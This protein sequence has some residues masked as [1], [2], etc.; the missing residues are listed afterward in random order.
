MGLVLGLLGALGGAVAGVVV[1]TGLNYGYGWLSYWL[2]RKGVPQWPWHANPIELNWWWTHDVPAG[3]SFGALSALIAMAWKRGKHQEAIRMSQ[4]GGILGIILSGLN[5][6]VYY[7]SS[8]V[9][10]NIQMVYNNNA[11]AGVRLALKVFWSVFGLD[12]TLHWSLLLL[13]TSVVLK[14]SESRIQKARSIFGLL[15]SSF[16]LLHSYFLFL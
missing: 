8:N 9:V 10:S 5:M 2:W 14:K 12:V 6:F 15:A 4:W 1:V 7:Y 16:L 13:V 11:L 3:G